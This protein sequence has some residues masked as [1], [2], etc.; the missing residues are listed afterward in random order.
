MILGF[1]Q[2][3]EEKE[4]IKILDEGIM[5]IQN[6]L[7]TG[8]IWRTDYSPRVKELANTICE[9]VDI[10]ENGGS[11]VEVEGESKF[12][13]LNS[14]NREALVRQLAE[15]TKAYK[16]LKSWED[17]E[18]D[19]IYVAISDEE[20]KTYNQTLESFV[21]TRLALTE[22]KDIPNWVNTIFGAVIKT[23]ALCAGWVITRKLL[24]EGDLDKQ[25]SDFISSA[26]R[27]F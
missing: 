5:E 24:D 6:V 7:S 23:G 9:T 22:T 11:Y 21:K 25:S 16:E 1:I 19:K 20:R 8:H 3:K 4:K 15:T 18:G 13:P 14:Q 12:L 27:L 2:T 17:G 10:L 26:K